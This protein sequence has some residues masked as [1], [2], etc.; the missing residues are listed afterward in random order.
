V[1]EDEEV[2]PLG[3][4]YKLEGEAFWGA[5]TKFAEDWYCWEADGKLSAELELELD[6]R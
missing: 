5:A 2:L 3:E 4:E 6:G 1:D